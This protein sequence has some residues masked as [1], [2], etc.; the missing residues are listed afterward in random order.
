MAVSL[1]IGPPSAHPLLVKGHS[2]PEELPL[3]SLCPLG[4]E[5]SHCPHTRV[6][7]EPQLATQ[8]TPSSWLQ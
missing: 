8:A 4:V 1:G 6:G 5:L 3:P 2:V 7:G